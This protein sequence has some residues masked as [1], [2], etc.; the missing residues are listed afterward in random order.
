MHISFADVHGP[1]SCIFRSLRFS[2]HDL[3]GYLRTAISVYSSKDRPFPQLHWFTWFQYLV[4]DG[5]QMYDNII[6]ILPTEMSRTNYTITKE[7]FSRSCR[8]TIGLLIK[9]T[10]EQVVGSM[11][12][13]K[14]IRQV[15]EPWQDETTYCFRST[16]IRHHINNSE[17]NCTST[18]EDNRRKG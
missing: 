2:R 10:T 17:E 6:N 8:F 9:P 12:G 14:R 5:N 13:I 3:T 4:Q 18:L 11:F 1:C 15:Y 7:L 16:F